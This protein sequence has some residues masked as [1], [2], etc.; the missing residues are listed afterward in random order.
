MYTPISEKK[1]KKI[2]ILG[3]AGFLG[4][5][6]FEDLWNNT[7]YEF[8]LIDKKTLILPSV[9]RATQGQ[10][11]IK[12]YIDV[13]EAIHGSKCD[14]IINCA[15]STCVNESIEKPFEVISNNINLGLSSLYAATTLDIPLIQLQSDEIYGPK[16]IDEAYNGYIRPSN[17]YSASKAAQQ[18]IIQAYRSTYYAEVCTLT[19]TNNFGKYQTNNKFTPRII[20]NIHNNVPVPIYCDALG[21]PHGYRIWNYAGRTAKVLTKLITGCHEIYPEE[22]NIV[23]VTMD[24]LHYVDLIARLM[25]KKYTLEYVKEQAV[26]P[27]HDCGY[28]LI[29]TTYFTGHYH[30]S[31]LIEDLQKTIA[32]YTR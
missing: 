10:F 23:G 11:E 31:N 16:K 3:H 14:L 9:Y 28:Q 25:G 17:P 24:N 20:E 6:I 26:R 19:L 13:W 27:G 18:A 1:I 32:F 15:G 8:V 2:C 21:N 30:M 7:D 22:I 4:Q 12:S 5:N 29:D